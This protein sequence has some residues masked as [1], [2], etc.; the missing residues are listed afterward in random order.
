MKCYACNNKESTNTLSVKNIVYPICDEC[1]NEYVTY[2]NKLKKV[3][4]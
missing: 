1:L 4:K 2:R 3:I